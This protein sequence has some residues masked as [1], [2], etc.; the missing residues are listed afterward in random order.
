MSRG[1]TPT[2]SLGHFRVHQPNPFV[3]CLMRMQTSDILYVYIIFINSSKSLVSTKKS[4][5]FF[6]VIEIQFVII[7]FGENGFKFTFVVIFRPLYMKTFLK[8]SYQIPSRKYS[9]IVS[10]HTDGN[11]TCLT[12]I[13]R[14]TSRLFPDGNVTS[15]P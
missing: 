8:T 4:Q 2:D 5:E 7:Y 13:S 15:L 3:E 14:R 11:R 10:S 6:E 12:S 1:V 9:D